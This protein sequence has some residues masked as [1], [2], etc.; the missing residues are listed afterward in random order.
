MTIVL[1]PALPIKTKKS[2]GKQVSDVSDACF[3]VHILMGVGIYLLLK[4][5]GVRV[6]SNY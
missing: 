3:F 2:N 6:W 5:K 1:V 4:T